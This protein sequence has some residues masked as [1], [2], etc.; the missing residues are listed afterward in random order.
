MLLHLRSLLFRNDSSR[1]AQSELLESM[2]FLCFQS[3]ARL[4]IAVMRRK[5]GLAVAAV[6]LARHTTLPRAGEMWLGIGCR[7]PRFKA[8]TC[9]S[10]LTT[11][12]GPLA[13]ILSYPHLQ[14][15]H[16]SVTFM[17]LMTRRVAQSESC[18]NSCKC[19]TISSLREVLLEHF[20]G[21]PLSFRA[22]KCLTCRCRL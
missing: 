9:I 12:V 16:V 19:K 3:R 8:V 20:L 13:T 11:S 2:S 17:S 5:S 6:H 1:C 7:L 4:S 22:G 18:R 10:E 14:D 21:A 15:F